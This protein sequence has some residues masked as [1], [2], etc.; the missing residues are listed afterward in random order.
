MSSKKDDLKKLNGV[1]PAFEKRINKLGVKTFADLVALTD[2]KIEE[3]EKEANQHIISFE[4]KLKKANAS[5]QVCCTSI[6]YYGF[7]N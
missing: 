3:L 2:E 7:S 4:H 5:I 6:F 1:G